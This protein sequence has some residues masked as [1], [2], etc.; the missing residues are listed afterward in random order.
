MVVYLPFQ[1]NH[2]NNLDH[3][4]A[5]ETLID[6][7]L[8]YKSKR[9]RVFPGWATAPFFR[10][11][12]SIQTEKSALETKLQKKEGELSVFEDAK[13]LLVANEGDLEVAVPKFI[14]EKLG[15]PTVRDEAYNE[16][17]WLAEEPGKKSAICEVKSVTKGFKKGSIYE[18]YTHREN[19]GL[20]V[21]F[22]ALLF[23]NANLQAAS[24]QTKDAR[25]SPQDQ[26]TA[27]ENNVL[28]VR[29]EDLVRIWDGVRNGALKPEEVRRLFHQSKGW[30]EV[31]SELKINVRAGT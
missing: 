1:R 20:E 14:A 31:T 8:T 11:E 9:H 17:F 25:I 15:I 28:I 12:E 3:K 23:V 21:T 5:V 27:C 18:L 24:W 4:L 30:A 19:R 22:P 13:S 29:I 16:D 26:K 2:L 10:E 6:A 7:L